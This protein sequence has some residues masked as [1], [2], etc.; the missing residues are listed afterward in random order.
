MRKLSCGISLRQRQPNFIMKQGSS[1]VNDKKQVKEENMQGKIIKGIAGFYYVH[2]VG[3]GLYECKAKGIFR[4]RKIKP[5]VGDNVEI[6]VLD[7]TEKL[8]NVAELLP[9]KNALLRPAVANVDQALVIFAIME[10]KP[11][12]NLL[13]R[14][15]ITM[16]KQGVE[17]VICF[18]KKDLATEMEMVLLKNS[19]EACGYPIIFMSSQT[20]EG[21]ELVQAAIAHKTTVLAG[22]SG[23][24][25]SSLLNFLNPD[26]NMETGDISAKIKRGKHTT[27]HSEIFHVEGD[28]YLM[29]T[30]GFTS[31]YIE[32]FE[33]ETLKDYFPEFGKWEEKCRFHG[34]AH[35]NEPDCAVKQA[36]QKGKISSVRYQS[37]AD[38]YQ[39][40]KEQKKY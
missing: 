38:L 20:G 22:P 26:A 32:G 37:Y 12:F 16:E 7:E 1:I 34:C 6:D 5:L 15:L 18:N 3:H 14:F 8:G 24:G 40:L 39:E 10:P 9:R 36:L 2:V 33:K 31:L 27:R 19:Y 17:T 30:P 28:T 29:D 35:L 4:N 11:N 13:D 25:K 23:V 21:I